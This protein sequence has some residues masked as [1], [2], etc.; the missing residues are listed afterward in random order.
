[1][2]TETLLLLEFVFLRVKFCFR[3]Q[4]GA[5]PTV[6]RKKACSWGIRIV[7]ETLADSDHLVPSDEDEG[8]S[9]PDVA[10][11]AERAK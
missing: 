5:A 11:G 9:E 4:C 7:P 3:V 8:A 1:M 2:K 6:P 10:T